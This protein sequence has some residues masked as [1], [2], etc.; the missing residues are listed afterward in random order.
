MR[1]I[2]RTAMTLVA[3]AAAALSFQSLAH[4][5]ELAGYG[6]LSPLYPV[7]V[8]AGAAASCAAWLHTRARQPLVMTWSLLLVSVI[9]NGTAHWLDS[10]GSAPSW[11]LIV[12]VA[13]IPPLVLGCCVHLAV[14][15]G[16]AAAVPDDFQQSGPVDPPEDFRSVDPVAELIESG[17]GRG[18]LARE[19]GISEHQA[20]QILASRNGHAR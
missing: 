14:G 11:A 6:G 12:G 9:L 18:V 4:L 3:L 20:R 15:M 5:G 8:D 10:T 7:V 13:A 16:A 19:L 2:V 1:I 17:A